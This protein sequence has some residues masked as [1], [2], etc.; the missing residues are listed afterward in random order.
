LSEDCS[1][2]LVSADEFSKS[3]LLHDKSSK[4]IIP[5]ESST[6]SEISNSSS[7]ADNTHDEEKKE[8]LTNNTF[9]YEILSYYEDNCCEKR[10][11]SELQNNY[12]LNKSPLKVSVANSSSQAN[13]E[14]NMSSAQTSNQSFKTTSPF[15]S[16][17]DN[18][19]IGSSNGRLFTQ[20]Y[21]CTCSAIKLNMKK[22]IVQLLFLERDSIKYYKEA[23]HCYIKSLTDKLFE[24]FGSFMV[25]L[26]RELEW[27]LQPSLSS[28]PN[29][30]SETQSQ[31]IRDSIEETNRPCSPSK[32]ITAELTTSSRV[33]EPISKVA[34]LVDF[35]KNQIKD[36]EENLY[37]PSVDEN[38]IPLLFRIYD[39]KYDHHGKL[40]ERF[41][42]DN[43]G[44]EIIES[45]PKKTIQDLSE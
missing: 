13:M 39:P 11:A 4:H 24:Q 10:W 22:V 25:E 6:T 7:S 36:L 21:K 8:R 40:I 34:E 3:I 14:N 29:L 17:M 33:F 18:T 12:L 27:T 31:I 26:K 19:N 28:Y 5:I 32:T 42:I 37:L 23:C 45:S 15:K 30:V 1:I 41:D 16:A 43:D 38:T 2:S 9:L 20:T 35:M 44:F